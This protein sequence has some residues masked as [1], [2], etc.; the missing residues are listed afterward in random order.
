MLVEG[1]GADVLGKVSDVIAPD[2][3]CAGYEANYDKSHETR[4]PSESSTDTEKNNEGITKADLT[5]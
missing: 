1:N 5:K 2:G 4:D 3:C